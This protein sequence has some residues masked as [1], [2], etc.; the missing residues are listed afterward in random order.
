M[1]QSVVLDEHTKPFVQV[2][3]H[4][5]AGCRLLQQPVHEDHAEIGVLCLKDLEVLSCGVIGSAGHQD[6]AEGTIRV[7]I[8]RFETAWK[9]ARPIARFDADHDYFRGHR[10][11]PDAPERA[12]AV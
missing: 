3:Q 10:S 1:D 12:S 11:P 7:R 2:L 6:D 5:V 4:K 8:Q 9:Y